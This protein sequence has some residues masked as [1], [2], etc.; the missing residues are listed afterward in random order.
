MS[1]SCKPMG[2]SLMICD[3]VITETE[4]NKKSLIGVFNSISAGQFPCRH[5]KICIFVSITGG[6]GKTKSRVCCINEKTGQTLFG[7]EGDIDFVN[8]NHVVEAVFEFNNVVFPAPGLHCIEV[9]SN[10]EL[11]LQ[12]RFAVRQIKAEE[13][14]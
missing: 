8:P 14:Q 13:P 11:V 7:A 3:Q 6:H 4:T 12:R 9:L 1:A 10:G 2:I 5:P